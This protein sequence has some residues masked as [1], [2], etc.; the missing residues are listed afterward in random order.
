QRAVDVRTLKIDLRASGSEDYYTAMI[1][2]LGIEDLVNL[3][4]SLPYRQS[5][6]DCADADGLLL[7]QAASCNH[8]IPAKV[9]EYLRLQRPILPFTPDQRDTAQLLK[10]TGGATIVDPAD[11]EGIY[12][13]LPRFLTAISYKTHPLPNR[14]KVERYARKRQALDFARLLFQISS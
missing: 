14:H 6:Q 11:E 5:L 3:L 2:N 7:F 8:L 4:P 9:Y 1:R 13:T 12:R 10:E